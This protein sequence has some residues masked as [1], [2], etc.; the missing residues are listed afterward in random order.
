M[1]RSY[2]LVDRDQQFLLPPDMAEWLPAEH[3]VWFLIDVVEQ[4]DTSVFHRR[5]PMGGPGRQAYDPDMLLTLLLY[6]YAVGERSSRRIERLCSDHVAFRVICAQDPPDHTTIAR[7]RAVHEDAFADLFARVLVLCA[8]AGM[9]RVGV[10]SVDGTKI[11]ADASMG[12]NRT[13]ETLRAEAAR[14]V[15][16]AAEVDA[17]EDAEFGDARGDELPPQFADPHGRGARIGKAL[18]EIRKQREQAEEL[19]EAERARAAEYLR[20]VEAGE[21]PPGRPPSGVDAARVARAR[22]VRAKNRHR[23]ARDRHH[24][25]QAATDVRRAER[26]VDEA[27]AAAESA[28]W[29]GD[30]GDS[31]WARSPA[32]A[33]KKNPH[34][35]TTDPDSRLMPTRLGWVQG[36]NAQ[37]AVS[38]DH[39]ILATKLVQDTGDSYSFEPMMRA[40]VDAAD[41][42]IAAQPDAQPNGD[43]GGS[44]IGTIL[45]DAGYLSEHNLTVD[46]PGRLIAVGKRKDLHHDAREYPTSGPPPDDA[47]PIEQM[48]HRLRTPE[49]AHTYK[50]RGATVE[51]VN[52]HL[53]DQVGL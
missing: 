8:G 11:A 14:I 44:G 4:I 12:A 40:A 31:S 48:R 50:R 5:H 53:K 28:E 6:A 18:E 3:L 51:P 17:A 33:G 29:P 2:R 9:G 42:V 23:Y 35:N 45:A 38:D 27:A 30:Q 16:E 20:R 43:D 32:R 19:S 24:R 46:G 52:A 36:F 26:A 41:T 21:A 25:Y 1:A 22:L 47:T 10:V 15:A 37:I 39:L 13:E 49:G 7:F 34:A